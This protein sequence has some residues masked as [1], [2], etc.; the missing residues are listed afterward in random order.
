LLKEVKNYIE[1]GVSPQIIIKGFRKASELALN[2]VKEL[3]VTI[4]R[5]NET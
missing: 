5:K 3:A 2:K 1:D 4:E